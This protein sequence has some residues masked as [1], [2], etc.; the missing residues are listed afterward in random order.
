MNR[1]DNK[2][3]KWLGAADESGVWHNAYHGTSPVNLSPIAEQGLKVGGKGVK[4]LNGAVY[5]CGVYVSPFIEYAQQYAPSVPV[6]GKMYQIVFQCRV[7]PNSYT[8][9]NNN[10]IWVVENG[11]SVRPYGICFRESKNKQKK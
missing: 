4:I 2:N 5:G 1:Y 9:H 11:K 8:K 3:N 10:K 6:K 7:K